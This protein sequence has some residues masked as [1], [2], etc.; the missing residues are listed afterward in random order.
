MRE[1]PAADTTTGSAI[2]GGVSSDTGLTVSLD[3]PVGVEER[4]EEWYGPAGLTIDG[5]VRE[6]FGDL[7]VGSMGTRVELDWGPGWSTWGVR[8]DESLVAALTVVESGHGWDP[9]YATYCDIRPATSTPAPFT[10]YVSNQSFADPTVNIV[11]AIDGVMVVDEDFPVEGQHN[12]KTFELDLSPGPHELHAEASTG[13]SFDAR[14]ALLDGE[15][16]WAVLDYWWYPDDEP[17]HF[18]FST[19]DEPVGFA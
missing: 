3:C 19:H 16:E 8:L 15:P 12:W 13:V 11:V 9:S 14:V 17:R 1:L 5:A 10:L 4:T 7:V 6:G 18:A 2:G